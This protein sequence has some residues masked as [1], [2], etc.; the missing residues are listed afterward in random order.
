MSGYISG[1]NQAEVDAKVKQA[2]ENAPE[3]FRST[4]PNRPPMTAL[5]G[6]PDRIVE[7]IKEIEDAGISRIM[8]QYRTPPGREDLEFVAREILPRV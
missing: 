6:L 8:L 3:R 7:Q 2:I 1:A 5:W 4:D